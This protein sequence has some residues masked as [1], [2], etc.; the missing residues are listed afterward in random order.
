MKIL[1]SAITLQTSNSNC[2]L[3]YDDENNEYA[4]LYRYYIITD[5][6]AEYLSRVTDEIIFYCPELELYIWGVTH[7]C[8][9]M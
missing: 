2:G 7:L 6:F 4:E 1:F 5:Q 8:T 9:E 3:D